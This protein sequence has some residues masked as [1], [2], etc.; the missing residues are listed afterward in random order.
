MC[1]CVC[2]GGGG[3]GHIKLS[4]LVF[5]STLVSLSPLPP[6]F[7]FLSLS[8]T[9]RIYWNVVVFAFQAQYIQRMF[10]KNNI[11]ASLLICTLYSIFGRESYV[12]P[13]IFSTL[14]ALISMIE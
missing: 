1:V 7:L 11:D 13:V 10:V 12:S 9:T 2:G 14:S 3:G 6:L 8:N 4:P 5:L